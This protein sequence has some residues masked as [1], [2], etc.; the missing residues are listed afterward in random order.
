M[1]KYIFDVTE[2]WKQQ[3]TV[4][5]NSLAD[6]KDRAQQIQDTLDIDLSKST[7]VT[8]SV[9]FSHEASKPIK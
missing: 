2:T 9:Q 5:A 7:Y 6:A 3:I 8:G 1:N 4:E